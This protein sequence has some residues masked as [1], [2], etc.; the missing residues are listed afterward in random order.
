MRKILL[1]ILLTTAVSTQA[2][3]FGK[4]SPAPDHTERE[5]LQTE[6]RLQIQQKLQDAQTQIQTQQQT[7]M[8]LHTTATVIGA[9]AVILLIVGVAL[10]SKVKRDESSK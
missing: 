10:G 8:Q 7:I 3:W 2:S 1:L 5:R 9:S 6:Q 4:S